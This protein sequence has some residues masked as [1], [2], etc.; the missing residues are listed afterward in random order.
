MYRCPKCRYEFER[1]F[2]STYR[3]ELYKAFCPSCGRSLSP[4]AWKGLLR[5]VVIL[6]AV[7][8]VGSGLIWGSRY[9][10]DA[11]AGSASVVRVDVANLRGGP[12]K[13]ASVIRTLHRGDAVEVV[14]RTNE[15]SRV[16]VNGREGYIHSQLLQAR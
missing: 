3:G 8:L 5:I 1:P 9:F 4:S 6:V 11:P 16:R 7:Q 14:S 15:W 2:W 10:S 13:D 12:S